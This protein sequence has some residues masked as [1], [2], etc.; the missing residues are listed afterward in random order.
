MCS[1]RAGHG[2]EHKAEECGST[3]QVKVFEANNWNGRLSFEC[4]LCKNY[5]IEPGIGSASDIAVGERVY[6]R[7]HG[8]EGIFPLTRDSIG[9]RL[10]KER[11]KSK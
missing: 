4:P 3:N 7:C 10:W 1:L 5:R 6:I 2:V 11:P 8:C 9:R